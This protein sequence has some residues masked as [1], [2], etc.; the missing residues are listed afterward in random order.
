MACQKLLSVIV[1]P[2]SFP[3]FGTPSSQLRERNSAAV[4]PTTHRVMVRLK[5]LIAQWNITYVVLSTTNPPLGSIGSH[6]RNGVPSGHKLG[7][8]SGPDLAT[9]R[10]APRFPS[11]QHAPS[12]EP[13]E[14]LC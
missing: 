2:C 14:A 9:A 3:I 1:I 13:H 7:S 4:L 6:G 12:S 5:F 11:H 8:S 10:P